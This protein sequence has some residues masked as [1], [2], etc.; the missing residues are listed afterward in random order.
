MNLLDI[1]DISEKMPHELS[2]GQ[3]Q[4]VALA[5]ALAPRPEVILMDE[6]FS[7]LDTPLRARVRTE[8]R[9]ILKDTGTSAIFVTHDQDEAFA[10]AD[11]IGVMLSGT[12]AQIG[13]P[14]NIY[15]EPFSIDVATSMGDAN[16]L[17]GVANG[18]HIQSEIGNLPAK[19]KR[20]GNVQICLR[21]ETVNINSAKNE[22]ANGTV[23]ESEFY[24]HFQIVKTMLTSGKVIRA[25]IGSNLDFPVG[26][27]VEITTE[28]PVTVFPP[29]E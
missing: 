19:T 6:P 28:A 15:Q 23:I 12:I 26:S 25:K 7:N 29:T 17:D 22:H 2:G 13:S 10:L 16:I 21:P 27:H 24:G 8:I 14:R 5:R 1:H 9:T 3:Q 20:H 18:N 4:R 11:E